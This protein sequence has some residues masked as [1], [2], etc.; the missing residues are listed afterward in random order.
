MNVKLKERVN[1]IVKDLKA[2]SESRIGEEEAKELLKEITPME[3]SL[4][5][6]RL[7][8]EGLDPQKLREYCDL[9]LKAL[10]TQKEELYKSLPSGN[11]IKIAKLEH[12]EILKFLEKLEIIA[13]SLQT[14]EHTEDYPE[15]LKHI[16]AHLVEAEKHHEREEEVLFPRL[17]RKG[18]NGPPRIMRED[19]EKMRPQKARLKELAELIINDPTQ[20]EPSREEIIQLSLGLVKDLR[21]HIFKENNILYPTFVQNV[22]SDQEWKEIRERFDQIG[23][24]CFTP[25]DLGNPL[26]K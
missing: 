6:Q 1:K 3:I 5:E 9:H 20:E 12:D 15:D 25:G 8:Q 10:K 26:E 7:L 23:Y 4:A 2:I 24:C 21:D 14:G 16:A 19:H 22:E 17:E 13:E 18:I 11:P